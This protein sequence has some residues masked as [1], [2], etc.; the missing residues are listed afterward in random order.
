MKLSRARHSSLFIITMRRQNL[1]FYYF[2][3]GDVFLREKRGVFGIFVSFVL[4]PPQRFLREYGNDIAAMPLR[5]QGR[6]S[7]FD[8]RDHLPPAQ[9]VF[10]DK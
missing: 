6:K 7:L 10:I 3:G 1:L 2:E 5:E 8:F 4:R 9:A